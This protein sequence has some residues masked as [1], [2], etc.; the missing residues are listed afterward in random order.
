MN[1]TKIRWIIGLMAFSMMGLVYFQLFWI[2]SVLQANEDRFM[3]DVR[4]ALQIVVARLEKKEVAEVTYDNL[5]T[6]F[7]WQRSSGTKEVELFESTFEKKVI[8]FETFLAQ[9]NKIK[10]E[11]FKAAGDKIVEISFGDSLSQTYPKS[12]FSSLQKSPSGTLFF[13]P[14]EQKIQVEKFFD[15]LDI[16]LLKLEENLDKVMKKTEMVQVV[17]NDLFTNRR[18]LI[19]RLNQTELDSLIGQELLS[20]GINITYNFGVL[21]ARENKLLLQQ[22]QDTTQQAELVASV[23]RASLFPNDIIGVNSLLLV[24]FPEQK[25]FL[26]KKIWLT[27]SSS[28]LLILVIMFCFGY[29]IHTILR[30]KKLSDIKN[31]FISNMTHEFKTPIAT[32]SLACEAL[33]DHDIKQSENMINRYIKIISDENKRLGQQ[34]EKVLQMAVIERQDFKL[35]LEEIDF[36]EIIQKVLANEQ[37]QVE[38][39]GGKISA[40]LEAIHPKLIGDELHLTNIIHNLLDNAFKYSPEKP[41]ITIST[42]AS[43]QGITLTVEDQGIGMSKDQVSKIFERFYRV[44][45]GNV[46]NVKGFGLGLPYVKRIVELH[47]GTISVKSELNKGTAFNLFFPYT[48]E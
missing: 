39:R 16:N 40:R 8:D 14:G 42:N 18:S 41:N 2:N 19:N 35:K 3:Q 46:H 9:R 28:A 20:K 34:V 25:S 44:P 30:Q 10:E 23:M 4:D 37:L 48:H 27:L 17:I 7:Q 43:A 6:R 45:T 38:S 21:D 11:A 13:K 32:V 26:L 15:T 31:D 12:E 1:I 22:C 36:H 29:A 5:K 24:S 33:Q 47:D